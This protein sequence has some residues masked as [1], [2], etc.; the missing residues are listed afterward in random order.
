MDYGG[1]RMY[2]VSMR[3]HW[4]G[5]AACIGLDPDDFFNNEHPTTEDRAFCE[6][7]PVISFCQP[8]AIIHQEF[9]YQGALT[10]KE[11]KQIRKGK[12]RL[13]NLSLDQIALDQA[14]KGLIES[15]HLLPQKDYEEYM[16]LVQPL[17]ERI[18]A[19]TPQEM[20]SL[21]VL[22]DE[23]LPDFPDFAA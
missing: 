5:Q 19:P 21:R 16:A 8:Y 4:T 17:A 7:C 1:F 6:A 23:E 2:P 18:P 10:E 22:F 12:R 20:Q 13:G 3:A 9:G 15:D 14:E 11:R